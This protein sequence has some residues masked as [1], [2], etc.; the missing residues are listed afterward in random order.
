M[1]HV[2]GPIELNEDFLGEGIYWG[3]TYIVSKQKVKTIEQLQ[4]PVSSISVSDS[5]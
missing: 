2:A 5:E 1:I 4:Q 3:K